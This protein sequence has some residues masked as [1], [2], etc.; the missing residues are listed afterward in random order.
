MKEP[1]IIQDNDEIIQHSASK[2]FNP[3]IFQGF[4]IVFSLEISG[5]NSIIH[6]PTKFKVI[7]MIDKKFNYLNLLYIIHY[8]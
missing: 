7:D 1:L 8:L 5:D 4:H 6:T 2:Y 3:D